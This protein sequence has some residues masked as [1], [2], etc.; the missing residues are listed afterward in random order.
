MIR[1]CRSREF[2]RVGSVLDAGCAAAVTTRSGAASAPR[3]A[4]PQNRAVGRPPLRAWAA[5]DPPLG[6]QAA[7]GHYKVQKGR[8]PRETRG[9]SAPVRALRACVRRPEVPDRRGAGIPAVTSLWRAGRGRGPVAT[10]SPRV[11]EPVLTAES[12]P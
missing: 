1:T 5:G 12:W 2:G 11:L 10:A 7:G 4:R 6:A 3:T 8:T 9:K